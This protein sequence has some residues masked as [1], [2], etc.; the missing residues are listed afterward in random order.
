MRTWQLRKGAEKRARGGHPWVFSNELSASPKGAQPGELITLLDDEGKFVAYGYGN[1]SSLIAFRA[2]SY[3]I[4]KPISLELI[5]ESVFKA[6]ELR[7][8]CGLL[9]FSHRLIFAEGDNL[10]GLIIDRYKLSEPT[11]SQ[12]FVIQS[13]TAGMDSLL[14]HVSKSIESLVDFEKS[15]PWDKTAIVSANTSRSRQLE[16]IP[17]EEKKIIKSVEGL[18]LSRVKALLQSASAPATAI[19]MEFDI[20]GGQKTG[21][22]LDQREN[23]RR[24]HE[25]IDPS[26]FD[27]TIRVLDLCCY[28]GQWSTQIA[29]WAQANNIKSEFT[30]FDSSQ[31]ALNFANSNIRRYGGDVIF[32]KGDVMQSLRGTLDR[33]YDIVIC[34]PPAFIKKKKDV[35]TGK[36]AYAKLNREAL[37]RVTDG[38]IYVTCSC[39]GLFYP[40]EF[41]DMLARISFGPNHSVQ[42]IKQGFHSPD[43][44]QR[45]EFPEGGYLKSYIGILSR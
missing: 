14:P 2:L 16:N 7:R 17:V 22:F 27:G 3:S 21:F 42:W 5:Q 4:E 6:A 1:P 39:S 23:I 30:I 19:E 40:E 32:V 15:V 45:M 43:H 28:V 33:H 29:A 9:D 35:P 44:P 36:A 38:G 10:P 31:D 12:V 37:K 41:R 26:H 24:L 18:N 11:N 25:I 13:S 20:L 8:R 34:D